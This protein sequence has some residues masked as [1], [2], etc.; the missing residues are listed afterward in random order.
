MP[1]S[2]KPGT[3]WDEVYARA[4]AVAPEAFEGDRILNL[5]GGEW[6][7]IGRPGDHVTPVDGSPI[8]G[9]SRVDHDQAVAAV[10]RAAEEHKAWG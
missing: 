7:R 10:S 3:S 8:P 4:C 9:P 6:Q 5:L 2:L 1:L